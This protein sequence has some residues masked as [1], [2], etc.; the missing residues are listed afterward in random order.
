LFSSLRKKESGEKNMFRYRIHILSPLEGIY[1]STLGVE[2]TS[3][4]GEAGFYFLGMI[5]QQFSMLQ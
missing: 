5:I 2:A 1:N 4:G 3:R